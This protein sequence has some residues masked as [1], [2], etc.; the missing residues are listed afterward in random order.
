MTVHDDLCGSDH[1]PII[2]EGSDPL[3]TECTEN[4]K[5]NKA[6]WTLFESICLKNIS[7]REFECQWDP[8]QKI[9]ESLIS[10]ANKC[11]SKSSASSKRIK[12]PWFTDECKIAIK[13]REKAERL[14][15][16]IPTLVNINNFRIARAKA[17]RTINQSKRK[18]WKNYVSNL[19]MHTRLE[20][21]KKNY[22]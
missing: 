2:D 3:K 12:R 10:I 6:D 17:R 19:N 8:I 21:N 7:I 5:L 9:T 11:V 16:K 15:N 14:F 1:F 4:W 18:S 22:R 20:H 13:A